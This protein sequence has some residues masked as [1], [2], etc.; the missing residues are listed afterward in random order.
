MSER[1]DQAR[2]EAE[3][4]YPVGPVGMFEPALRA[5]FQRGAEWADANPQPRTIT[6]SEELD[7]LPTGSIVLSDKGHAWQKAPKRKRMS[8]PGWVCADPIYPGIYNHP[9]SQRGAI[10][11]SGPAVVLHLPEATDDPVIPE[12]CAA[13]GKPAEGFAMINDERFCHPDEG[14]SCYMGGR[15]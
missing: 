15:R 5:A 6:T 1:I 11:Y 3:R 10:F 2:A 9:D 13:C 8:A 7:A 4:R 14:P 12:T